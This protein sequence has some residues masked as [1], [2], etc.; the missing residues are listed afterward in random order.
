MQR[1]KTGF[2]KKDDDMSLMKANFTEFDKIVDLLYGEG[3]EQVK[4]ARQLLVLLVD[5]NN[6]VRIITEKETSLDVISRTMKDEHKKQ[7]E[8]LLNLL[9]FFYTFSFYQEFHPM[10]MSQSIGETC[11]NIIEFQYAKYVV[12]KNEIV[13]KEAT[14][15]LTNPRDFQKELDKFLFLVRKQDRILRLAFTILMHMAED[16]KVEMKMVKKDIVCNLVRNLDRSNINLIVVILL[17]LKKLSIYDVNKEAMIK[18]NLL[19]EFIKLFEIQ[20]HVVFLLTLQNIFNLSFDSK[21]RNL[22]I[23]KEAFFRKIADCFKIQEFRGLVLRILYNLSLEEKA[24]KLFHETDCLYILYELLFNFPEPII[25]IELAALTLNLTTDPMNAQK[26]AS[27]GRVKGLLERAFKYNDFHLIKIVKNILKYSEDDSVNEIFESFIDNHFMKILKNKNESIEFL[28][29]IIEILSN[30]DTEWDEK[31]SEHGLIPWFER[32]LSE[33]SKQ[34]Y[35][36]LLLQVILFLGNIAS[37]KACA[38]LI[39]KSKILQLLYNTFEKKVHNYSLVFSIIYTLYQLIPWEE[40][41]KIILSMDELIKLVLQCLKCENNRIIFVSLNF[42][43]IVQLFEPKWSESIKRKK[44]KIMNKDF[45]KYLKTIQAKLSNLDM[46]N[47]L[48]MNDEED[49]EGEEEEYDDGEYY[50]GNN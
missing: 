17:F 20:H 33:D 38:P 40:T 11:I 39:S 28:I 7:V 35:D 34:S 22:I 42:L 5:P 8:L 50:Y 32:M 4:G 26:L 1:P 43:E 37:N 13:R 19:D 31:L 29:E 15:K 21:F 41:R 3:Q 23:E 18:Y 48:G 47:G 9:S 10:L 2:K 27:S 49:E 12:R 30:V 44:F 24:K 16:P 25:G 46:K 14:T 45:I 36:E 6:I